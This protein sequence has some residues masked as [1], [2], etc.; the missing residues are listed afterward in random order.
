MI[1]FR[2]ILSGIPYG[3]VWV[4]PEYDEDNKRAVLLNLSKLPE[5]W[6]EAIEPPRS[7]RT[8]FVLDQLQMIIEINTKPEPAG[9]KAGKGAGKKAGRKPNKGPSVSGDVLRKA[10]SSTVIRRCMNKNCKQCQW[11]AITRAAAVAQPTKPTSKN[12]KNAGYDQP[13]YKPSTMPI[14]DQCWEKKEKA[15]LPESDVIEVPPPDVK[16]SLNIIPDV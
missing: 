15:P 5:D 11:S 13:D 1:H 16:V 2:S 9:K 3:C 8:Q 7:P 12:A 6:L 10:L 14:F 4:S